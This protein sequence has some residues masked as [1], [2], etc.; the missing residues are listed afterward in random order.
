[1]G[2]RGENGVVFQPLTQA[3]PSHTEGLWWDLDNTLPVGSQ[4]TMQRFPQWLWLGY[5]L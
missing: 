4:I 5:T 3:C 1:M 2:E